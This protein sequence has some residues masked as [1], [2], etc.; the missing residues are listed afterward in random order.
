MMSRLPFIKSRMRVNLAGVR[1][2]ASNVTVCWSLVTGGETDPGTGGTVGGTEVFLSG[3]L[4]AFGL[5]VPAASVLRQHA[6]V[7]AG[8]L[9]LDLDGQ[10]KVQLF[11][12]QTLSGAVPLDDLQGAGL[13]YVWNGRYFVA[14]EVGP[15][16][17][18]AW[19]AFVGNVE[20]HRT[21]L[22]KRLT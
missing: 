8:D 16:L 5:E 7:A 3:T 18:R 22:L 6:E 20:L 2:V 1:S 11:P 4:R 17:Q 14:K 21:L 9:I 15:D 12:G 13:R 19:D 10:P